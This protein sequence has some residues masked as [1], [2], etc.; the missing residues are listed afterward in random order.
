MISCFASLRALAFTK[1]TFSGV[2]PPVQLSDED[3]K[4]I[5]A[6]SREINEYVKSV[7]EIK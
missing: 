6:V 7:E 4:F 1:K 3:K 2:L 5:A